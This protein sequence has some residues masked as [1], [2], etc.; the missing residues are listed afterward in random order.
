[1]LKKAL[2]KDSI[3]EIKN[4]YKRFISI[5]IMALLGVGFFAGL[6]ATSPDMIETIDTY[7]KGQNVYDIQ[8]ISTLGLTNDDIDALKNVEGVEIVYGTDSQDGLIELEDNEIVSKVMCVEDIN[9]P[10]LIEG[11]LPQNINECVVEEAFLTG[12]NKKIGDTITIEIENQENSNGDEVQYLKQKELKIVGTVQSPLYI[13]LDRGTSS[14]G[15][16]EVNYFIYISNE[17][18]NIDFYTEI[19]VKVK[20]SEKYK[21][22]TNSYEKYVET[23]KSNIEK[24]KKEREEARYQSLITQANNKIIE[25]EQEFNKQ[26]QDGEN[27]I[28]QAEQKLQTARDE[29]AK[30][31]NEIISNEKK[32]NNEFSQAEKKLE[33]AKAELLKNITEFNSKKQEAEQGL[34]TAETQKQQLETN[35]NSINAGLEEINVNYNQILAK[36]KDPNLTEEQR[37]IL[38]QSKNLLENEKL[39]LENNKN[40]IQAGI[41]Q[42]TNQTTSA[43]QELANAEALIE[44][45]K[46]EIPKQE[47]NLKSQKTKVFNQIE[48]AKNQI[49]NAKVELQQGETELEDSKTEFNQKIEEAET[50]LIDAKEKVKEIE[51]PEWYI[52]DRNENTGYRSFKQDTES[53]ENLSLVFPI[54]FFAI[55]ALVSLTSMTR[56]VE[57][58]RQELGTLKALGYNKFQIS[59]KYILYSSLA[60]I[61]GSLIGMNIGFQLLPRLIWKMYSI[62]YIMPDISISFNHAYSSL[63]LS[64]IYICIVGATMYAILRELVHQPA[65]LLRPKAPKLG[66]RVLLEKITPIWKRLNFSQK[67][68]I[69]NIFRYKKRFLMTIIGIFGCTSLILAGFGLKDSISKILPYQYEKIFNYDIQVTLKSSLNSEQIQNIITNIK[70]NDKITDIIETYMLSG[71][72]KKENNEKD[73]QII[74][75]NN[76]DELN[77]YINLIDYKTEENLTLNNNGI[78]ITDKLAELLNVKEGDT[79][80]IETTDEETKEFKITKIVENYVSH[81]IYI[82]KDLYNESFKD[83]YSTNVLLLKDKDLNEEEQ[84]ELSKQMLQQKE[85]STITLT[86]T[87]MNSLN[88][89]MNSLNYVVLILIVSAGLLA[90]VVLYNLSNVNISERIRELATI[91]VLGFYDKEVYKY[92][93]RETMLLTIIGILFGLVGGYFLNF[94]IIGTCEIEMLRF[95]KVINFISYIYS[96]AITLIFTIVVNIVTYFSL[97]KIDMISSLKSVE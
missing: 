65:T 93:S 82:S 37:T 13:S 12:T 44:N 92:V 20:N 53:I 22:G 74:V 69:R 29:I 33:S 41:S 68:T 15:S 49:Q 18:I 84:Q 59:I 4:S 45:A 19:Y 96:I 56:M 91:K 57:E 36:L 38:E 10:K 70:N 75:P 86:S 78:Y 39:E 9:K 88:D 54:V 46:I 72:A 62:M 90:F 17:N 28:A 64:L 63:G 50:K 14:L 67:V 58:Q 26:K 25:A 6:R 51:N 66:K 30:G 3:K 47:A 31:E 76:N 7:F 48:Q 73:I 81:Y 95:P 23:I 94:Y 89:T 34:A 40:T 8:V 1:M 87:L 55:A 35:L 5:M 11:N 2:L 77:K 85:I 52:L 60:C 79:I 71:V 61:I 42:I 24:I 97:K 16:G 83:D 32:A 21:T 80:S 43:K 27:Q